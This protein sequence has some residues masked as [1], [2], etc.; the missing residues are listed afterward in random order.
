MNYKIC[1]RCS[2]VFDGHKWYDDPEQHSALA[3]Q[4]EAHVVLCPGDER[5]AK[6]QVDG[7]VS[8][9][10]EFLKDHKDEAINLIRNVSSQHRKRNVAARLLEVKDGDGELTIETTEVTLAERIGKEIEKAFSGDLDIDWLQGASFVRVNWHR[11]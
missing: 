6:R 11:D 8:L 9:K 2:A 10:G 7:V 3:K 4:A 1:E 5:I